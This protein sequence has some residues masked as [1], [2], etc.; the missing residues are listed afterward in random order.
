MF[1][2]IKTVAVPVKNQKKKAVELY[3]KTLGMKLITDASDMDWAE[4]AGSKIQRI[5]ACAVPA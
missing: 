4:L 2:A 1:K 3:K 5:N